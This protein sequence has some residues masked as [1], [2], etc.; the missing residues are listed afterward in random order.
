[1]IKEK[2]PTNYMEILKKIL[3][4][5]PSRDK[6]II[7]FVVFF[8]VTLG[9]LELL[10]VLLIA[11]L[12]SLAVRNISSNSPG[13]RVS[14]VLSLLNIDT[15][16]IQTQVGILG[17][18]A[19]VLMVLRSLFSL[20]L[21]RKML[22]FIGL[23]SATIS[24]NLVKKVLS[25][26]LEELNSKSSQSILYSVTN[27]VELL[28]NGVLGTLIILV[29]D[30]ALSSIIIIGLLLIDKLLAI[31]TM[32]FFILV[33]LFLNKTLASRTKKVATLHT[34][35]GI[36]NNQLLLEVLGAYREIFV[37]NKRNYYIEKIGAGRVAIAELNAEKTFIP[38]ISKYTFEIAT[39]AGGFAIAIYQFATKDAIQAITVLTLFIVASARITPAILR[40]QQSALTF[41]SNIAAAQLTLDLINE[42]PSEVPEMETKLN[43]QEEVK[44][45]IEL[46]ELH[47]KY[48]ENDVFSIDNINLLINPGEFVALVGPSGSG[49]S[50]L[51]DLILG[52]LQPTRGDVLIDKLKPIEFIQIRPGIVS[53]VPQQTSIFQGTIRQNIALGFDENEISD[54]EIWKV[55]DLT[56]LADFVNSSKD[57]LNM[58]VGERG[59]KLSGGQKQRIGI[60]RALLTKPKILILDEATSALDAI[61]ENEITNAITQLRGVV[62]VVV[63]AHRLSTVKN[64]NKIIYLEN[65]Q[66]KATGSFE[67]VR[68]KIPDFDRQ[69]ELMGL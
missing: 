27:G 63:I 18:S 42:I 34:K 41:R 17:I 30:I 33:A 58:Q 43:S 32:L 28:I 21:N 40:I 47:F 7:S 64:A 48:K 36:R 57:G 14:R 59:T 37:K 49:K 39:V 29:A 10:S 35:Y 67:D 9:F 68:R 25:L 54:R 46:N 16:A 62:T 55:L 3:R 20:A 69:A 4:F 56:K 52:L 22:R 19:A 23:R 66:V 45:C 15:F 8:Q 50:T 12:G 1:M 6:R 31:G 60:A 11:A 13:N 38:S 53:Y 51:A 2:F 24:S 65:G 61:T 26:N 44:G 5:F